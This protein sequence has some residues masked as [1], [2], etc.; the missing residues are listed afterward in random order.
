[1][2]YQFRQG[3]I[4]IEQIEDRSLVGAIAV[5][6]DNGRVILAYGEATGHSHAFRS[7]DVT[8][9]DLPNGDRVLRVKRPAILYHEEHARIRVPAGLFRVIRQR[10]YSPEEIRTVAD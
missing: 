6:R 1:M 9:F 7:K 8:M 4:F 2:E 10:E 5:E 3:D